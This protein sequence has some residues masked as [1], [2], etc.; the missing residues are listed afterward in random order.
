VPSM[1]GPILRHFGER[2]NKLNAEIEIIYSTLIPELELA[3]WS[4]AL[5]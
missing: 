5:I 2:F 1:V 4:Y 3:S